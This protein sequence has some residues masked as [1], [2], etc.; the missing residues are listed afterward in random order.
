MVTEKE[1][2]AARVFFRAV[3]PVIKVLLEEDPKFARKFAGVTANIQIQAKNAPEDLAT[4]FKFVDGVFE[5]VPGLAENPEITLCFSSVAKMN[6]MFAGRP[7]L[8]RF[9]GIFCHFGLFVKVM[10]LLM[11]L[12]LL[13]PDAKPKSAEKARL[14]VKMTLY[15]IS[16]ALSQLNKAGDPAM[17][18]WTTKQPERV[19]QWSCEPEGIAAYLKIKAGNS[20]AGRGYYTRRKPFVHMKF[21]G[22]DAALAVLSNSVDMVK[23]MGEGLITVEG[24]PEYCA[25]LGSFMVRIAVLVS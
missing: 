7:V 11:G 17:V 4:Y 9:R 15:M 25:A 20:K 2:L 1:L 5:V 21:G 24:S 6:A 16:T 10:S 22:V 12:K 14:K 8:P 23:A 13:M 18:K 3:F 19:Y